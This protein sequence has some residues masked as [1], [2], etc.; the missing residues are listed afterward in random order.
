MLINKNIMIIKKSKFISYYYHFDNKDEV[1]IILNNI[2][3]EHKKADQYPYAYKLNGQIKKSDDNEPRGCAAIGITRAINEN[4]LD[5]CL[6]VVVR[7]FGGI[8]L[9]TGGLLRSYMK[10]AFDVIK[11]S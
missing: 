1:E 7:Y 9:G 2:K 8:K 10:S 4:N 11:K 5:N 3:S 6:I